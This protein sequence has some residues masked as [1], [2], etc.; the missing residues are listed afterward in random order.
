MGMFINTNVGALNANRN[1]NFNNTQMGKTM[2]KLSSGYR[3]NRAADDA[4]GLAISEKMRFQINGLT[5]AQR[6]AQDGISLIQTAEGALTEVHSML[7][8]LNTLANQAAN[9]TYDATDRA[10]IQ[11]EVDELIGEISN[12]AS[13]VNFNGISLLNSSDKVTFQ[14]GSDAN[15]SIS[16]QLAS[17]TPSDLGKSL[18]NGLKSLTVTGADATNANAAITA[19]KSAI[20]Q[21]STQRATFGAVQNRLEHTV[22]NLGVMVENLSASESRIRD[23]DMATEMTAFTKNQILVQAGTAMLAQA[24]SAPQSVLRLLG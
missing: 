16:I 24:N 7:Q 19:I 9:G 8:R 3:I 5:Q 20:S 6:N 21:V 10:K 4:A 1:L 13:T 15:T 17:L 11:L 22:N 18:A 12:I 2:E 23:A 14:I